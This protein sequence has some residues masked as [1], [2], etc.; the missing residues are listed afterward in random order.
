VSKGVDLGIVRD[1]LTQK[2]AGNT[3]RYAHFKP[4]AVRDAARKAGELLTLKVAASG[5]VV[6]LSGPRKE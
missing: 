1:L 5:K 2:H 4:D 3:E 6:N